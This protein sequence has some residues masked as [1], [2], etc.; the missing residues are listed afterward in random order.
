[1]VEVVCEGTAQIV[2]PVADGARVRAGDV[3]LTV[4]APTRAR[5]RASSETPRRL[6]D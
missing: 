3:L 1:V 5:T 2:A 6:Y 4:T